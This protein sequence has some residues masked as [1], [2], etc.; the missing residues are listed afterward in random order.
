MS[1]LRVEF[2]GV[3][4]RNPVLIA[5]S[6]LTNHPTKLRRLEEA[7]AGGIVTKLASNAV[8]PRVDRLPYRSVMLGNGAWCV[9]GGDRRL[10]LEEGVDLIKTAK[11]ELHIPI[12]ANV[13]GKSYFVDSWV[14]AALALEKAG[15]DMLEMGGGFIYHEERDGFPVFTGDS[16]AQ[17]PELLGALTK[18]LKSAVR[19]PVI[20]KVSQRSVDVS[21]LG[22]AAMRGGA[23]GLTAASALVGFA[24]VD[25]HNEGKPIFPG[26]E[27]EDGTPAQSL[28][29]P[30]G[31]PSAHVAPFSTIVLA[32]KV[33]LPISSVGGIMDWEVAVQRLMVGATTVQLCSTVYLNGLKAVTECVAGMDHFLDE[34]AYHSPT[35]IVGLG[36]PYIVDR[37]KLVLHPLKAV[38][39]DTSWKG[40]DEVV[41]RVQGDC[42]ALTMQDGMPVIDEEACTGCSLCYWFAPEGAVR[43]DVRE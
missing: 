22:L 9:A 30:M 12:I 6:S 35:D 19:I 28:S 41:E 15:A 7:G 27:L 43:I 37:E 36:L 3:E 2:A 11:K 17:Y 32:K 16:I 18:A 1:D 26:I 8:P 5:S 23:D 25:I 24:G 31:A 20:A 29:G 38:I 40:W 39:T 4:F 14:E 10:T 33:G 13:S 21:L 42:L 34:Y